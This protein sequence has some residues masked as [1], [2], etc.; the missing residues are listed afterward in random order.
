MDD[1]D[2]IEIEIEIDDRDRDRRHRYR[3]IDIDDI[4]I[5]IPR[6][7]DLKLRDCDGL[8]GGIEGEQKGAK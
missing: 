6:Y 3:W 5:D 7:Y 8:G 1:I 4:D 2:D